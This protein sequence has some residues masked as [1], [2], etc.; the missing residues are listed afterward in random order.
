MENLDVIIASILFTLISMV[1]THK[2]FKKMWDRPFE[3][4]DE[5]RWE[6]LQRMLRE[7]YPNYYE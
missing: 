3:N 4:P 2:L 7:N 1:M 6:M 5:T